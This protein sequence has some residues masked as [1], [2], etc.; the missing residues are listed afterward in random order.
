MNLIQPN[1][2]ASQPATEQPEFP[3]W[4]LL[5]KVTKFIS[6]ADF[7]ALVEGKVAYK[8]IS[9]KTV[10]ADSFDVF[11]DDGVR[12]VTYNFVKDLN[13]DF[14]KINDCYFG[15]LGMNLLYFSDAPVT[16]GVGWNKASNNWYTTTVGESFTVHCRGEEIDFWFFGDNRGG[17]FEFVVDGDVGNP[18]T[19]ST[20]A[21]ANAT[22]GRLIKTGLT[23]TMHTVV[24]TFKGADPT[25]A[26][27]G[28]TARGWV[29]ANLTD[30]AHRTVNGYLKGNTKTAQLMSHASN[31]EMAVQVKFGAEQSYVIPD[32][33]IGTAFNVEPIK[34][35]VD[36]AP[37][38]LST[39]T[40]GKPVPLNAS[41]DIQQHCY[42]VVPGHG[43]A[44]EFWVNHHIDRRGKVTYSTR[45]KALQDFLVVFSY[46]LMMPLSTVENT[47]LT[48][49][50]NM[51]VPAGDETDYYFEEE[52]DKTFSAALLSSVNKGYVAAGKI[53]YPLQS[54][55]V[56]KTGEPDKKRKLYIWQRAAVPK[57]YFR[58]VKD[59]PIRAG[60]EMAWSGE[61]I[62]AN[63]PNI[64]DFLTL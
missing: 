37:V 61:I 25:N 51:R 64:Y 39:Y 40:I 33:G 45:F 21:T 49:I 6:Q 5:D 2:P 34:I 55:R 32:H 14:W 26:P 38:D 58:S 41:V 10:S 29:Y 9:V 31:K 57:L 50:G 62:V 56:G 12:S 52:E 30:D 47:V 11:V 43:N 28:G 7:V 54:Y 3:D 16:S 42:G 13:D 1:M 22:M 48:S 20:Y 15:G 36:N 59:L 19:V 35:L 17:I 8:N 4:L 44:A 24:G 53:H 60:Q 23:D 27:A 18:V 46:P 63:I